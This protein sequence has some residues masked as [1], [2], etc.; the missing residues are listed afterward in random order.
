M[1]LRAG[2]HTG[3]VMSGI[4]GK[5]IPQFGV[6]GD[7]VNTASRMATTGEVN[8]IQ[9]SESVQKLLTQSSKC[10]II[11]GAGTKEVKGKGR[12][13]LFWLKGYTTHPTIPLQ[14]RLDALPCQR[15]TDLRV[16]STLTN[17]KTTAG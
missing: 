6:F 17:T 9:M 11:S 12:M 2:I 14:R 5:N 3:A 16:I 8:E 7:T 4:V 15:A 13:K 10:F 1:A